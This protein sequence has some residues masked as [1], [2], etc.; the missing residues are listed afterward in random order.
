MGDA[1][2][3]YS[4]K[5]TIQRTDDPK[6]PYRSTAFELLDIRPAA[7][8]LQEYATQQADS[9][10]LRIVIDPTNVTIAPRLAASGP[11]SASN[12]A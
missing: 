9:H 6:W 12:G 11:R 3:Y 7:G 5:V 8:D 4:A 10:N 1:S 2:V